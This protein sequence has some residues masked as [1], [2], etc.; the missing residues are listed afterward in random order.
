M[1]AEVSRIT[2]LRARLQFCSTA[3][4]LDG[5]PKSPGG[6]GQR[7]PRRAINSFQNLPK[8]QKRT[9]WNALLVFP[10]CR[11][12]A[13]P[14][15]RW[16]FLFLASRFASPPYKPQ[17]WY[18]ARLPQWRCP[19]PHPGGCA[20][21]TR[22]WPKRFLYS[23][24]TRAGAV[25]TQACHLQEPGRQARSLGTHRVMHPPAASKSQNIWVADLHRLAGPLPPSVRL[26]SEGWSAV[27]CC[28]VVKYRNT[29]LC[30][31]LKLAFE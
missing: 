10:C 24:A 16:A 19:L 1:S 29:I 2:F 26:P 18:F 17:G 12:G 7:W 30:C 15:V 27:V 5:P 6:V 13:T 22:R 4:F 14:L 3:L 21:S 28:D 25:F 11:A 9:R 31:Q 23:A 20:V 8:N